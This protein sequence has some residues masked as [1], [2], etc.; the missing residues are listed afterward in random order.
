[1]SENA[2]KCITVLGVSE[3]LRQWFG[4]ALSDAYSLKGRYINDNDVNEKIQ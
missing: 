2:S 3:M 4:S 1:M